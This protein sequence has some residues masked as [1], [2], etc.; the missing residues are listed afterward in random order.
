MF[1]ILYDTSF[2]GG[3]GKGGW[4]VTFNFK[5]ALTQYSCSYAF[6]SLDKFSTDCLKP[7]SM[8]AC[9]LR[10]PVI[11]MLLIKPLGLKWFNEKSDLTEK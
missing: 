1:I 3:G 2:R 4:K 8:C 9:V 7:L 5:K 10:L 11:Y 6:Q